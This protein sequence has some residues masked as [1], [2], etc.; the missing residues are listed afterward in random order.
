MHIQ[1]Y[2]C[3]QGDIFP[4]VQTKNRMI[5]PETFTA[6][7]GE[8]KSDPSNQQYEKLKSDFHHLGKKMAPK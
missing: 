1:I 2:A 7:W 6:D 4:K 5:L 8:T 3:L